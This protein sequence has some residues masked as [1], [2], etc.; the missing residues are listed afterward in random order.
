MRHSSVWERNRPK[1]EQEQDK[2]KGKRLNIKEVMERIGCSKSSAYN[3]INEGKLPSIT[4]FDSGKGVRV[5]EADV[6]IYLKNR[7][8]EAV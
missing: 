8:L 2:S 7:E 6:E 3:L 5:Y 1:Q 4:I